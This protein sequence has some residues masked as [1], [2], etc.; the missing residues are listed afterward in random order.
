MDNFFKRYSILAIVLGGVLWGV[1]GIFVNALTKAGIETADAVL[2]RCTLSAVVLF[3]Y[4]LIKEPSKLKI[5]LCDL[6]MFLGTGVV[7]F[8]VYSSTYFAAIKL[9]TMAIAAMLLYTSPIFVMIMSAIFY[10]ERITVKSAVA[11]AAT[12]AGCALVCGGARLDG[13]PLSGLLFG[14]LSGFTYAL[15][16]IFGRV[17]TSKYPP[18]TVTLYTFVFAG[19][20]SLIAGNPTGVAE[21]IVNN[22]A[23]LIP[24]LG[25]AVV[26][27][28][29]PYLLYTGGLKY[30]SP[31][32][33]A[34]TVCIE[35]V[36]AAFV[37]IIVFKESMTL[38]TIIGSLLI[39]G[40]IAVKNKY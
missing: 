23:V 13:Y 22:P 33:A 36:V 35:P 18:E 11:I 38:G 5:K 40:S 8:F 17:A 32:V 19:I 37:G 39:L 4:M 7:S 30:T 25:Y 3:V 20:G 27:S 28:V 31:S 21:I 12:V 6:W 2:I 29:L 10:K 9:T 26:C 14:L 34:V 24:G 15:Y 16:S 1:I